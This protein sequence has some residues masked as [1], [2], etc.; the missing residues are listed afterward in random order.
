MLVFVPAL[1]LGVA[2]VLGAIW[3]KRWGQA[4]GA[5][6]LQGLGIGLIVAALI[7]AGLRLAGAR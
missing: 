7:G 4:R 3:L 1:V 5:G 2:C 6:F